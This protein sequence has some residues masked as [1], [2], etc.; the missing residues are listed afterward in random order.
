TR[1]EMVTVERA[2]RTRINT[3][4]LNNSVTIFDPNSTWI[5]SNVQIGQ[6]TVIYPNSFLQG[7]TTIGEDCHIGPNVVLKN[8]TIPDNTTIKPFTHLEEG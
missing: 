6:D 7:N 5:D 1:A 2:I 8:V 4:W 3:H